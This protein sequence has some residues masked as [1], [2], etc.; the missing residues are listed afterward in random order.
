MFFASLSFAVP[1][2]PGDRWQNLIAQQRQREQALEEAT[3]TEHH[4]HLDTSTPDPAATPAS[5]APR[6]FPIRRVVLR[7]EQEQRFRFALRQALERLHFQAG[8]CLDAET[9]E[10]VIKDAQNALI[11]KGYTTTR[12]LAT[13]Q[14]LDG[15]ELVLTVLAGKIHRFGFTQETQDKRHVHGVPSRF[16]VFPGAAGAVLNLRDLEQGLENLRRVPTVTAGIRIVP[17]AVTNESDVLVDWSQ[18]VPPY[19]VALHFDDSGSR[20]TGKYLA[21]LTISAD[22]PLG[23]SDLLYANVQQDIGGKKTR[24]RDAFGN[25]RTSGTRSYALHYSVPW[26][27]W[28]FSAQMNGYRY[29]QAVAGYSQNYDYHGRNRTR[30]LSFRRLLH[31]DA[32]RK[33][34]L[35]GGLW[36]RILRRYID[37]AE[38]EVQKSRTAGWRL[39]LKHKE[40]LGTS[41]WELGIDYQRGTGMLGSLAAPGEAFDE[42]RGRMKILTADITVYWPF[43][44]AEHA[45]NYD[46]KLHLQWPGTPLMSQDRLAIGGR[47][48]VRGFD[49]ERSLIGER[50]WYLRNTLGW[51]YRSG[52]QFYLGLDVGRVSGPSRDYMLGNTLAGTVVG[53]KGQVKAG[54]ALRYDLFAGKPLAAPDGFSGDP[55]TLGFQLDYSF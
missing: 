4:I 30:E 29:H 49:G 19:R 8:D 35:R 39:G 9:I 45:F 43:V 32:H 40:Y 48:S 23:L 38:L 1:S 14:N 26:G 46:G 2:S 42:A 17:G 50:G 7:G 16:N 28:L 52:Q 37:D 31:R 36:Q 33:T 20:A 15:G 10:S 24:L 47:Y 27:N 25:R 22:N 54:G 12:I 3:H 34:Y 51:E 6:C 21:G 13:P 44:I 11:A 5:A 18:R 53:I 55:I 41:T